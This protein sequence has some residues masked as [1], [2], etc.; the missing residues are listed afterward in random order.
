M[1]GKGY[2]AH[3]T[4]DAEGR[5]FWDCRKRTM[6]CLGEG[7]EVWKERGQ[8]GLGRNIC[9]QMEK[10]INRAVRYKQTAGQCPHLAEHCT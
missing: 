4:G 9:G 1:P 5:K 7:P 3:C 10:K 8:G 6:E 2:S